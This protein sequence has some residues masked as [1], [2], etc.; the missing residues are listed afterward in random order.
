[1]RSELG[2]HTQ[3]RKTACNM[4]PA[5]ACQHGLAVSAAGRLMVSAL[6]ARPLQLWLAR[7]GLQAEHA[8]CKPC[9]EISGACS[10]LQTH[11]VAGSCGWKTPSCPDSAYGSTSDAV[12]LVCSLPDHTHGQRNVYLD[13]C[14]DIVLC[15]RRRPDWVRSGRNVLAAA[16]LSTEKCPG[17]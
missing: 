2:T 7:E 10:Q 3:R 13:D 1:M 4:P 5:V 15:V 11:G 6:C 9:H 12:W 16:A 17:A 8:L 14:G